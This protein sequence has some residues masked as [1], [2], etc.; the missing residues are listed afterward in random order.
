MHCTGQWKYLK[1]VSQNVY[2]FKSFG[3]TQ[4]HTQLCT[5]PDGYEFHLTFHYGTVY[6]YV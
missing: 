6:E 3:T 2:L 5:L 4:I 1:A